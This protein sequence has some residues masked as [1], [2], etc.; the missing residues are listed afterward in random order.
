MAEQLPLRFPEPRYV[1]VLV[2]GPKGTQWCHIIHEGSVREL[3]KMLADCK[4]EVVS[5]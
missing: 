2:T 4:V 1:R 5:G 3:E